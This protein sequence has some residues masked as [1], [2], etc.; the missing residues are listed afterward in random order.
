VST[1]AHGQGYSKDLSSNHGQVRSMTDSEVVEAALNASQCGDVL[2]IPSRQL[3]TTVLPHPVCLVCIGNKEF[4][5]EYRMK[6]FPQKDLLNKHVGTHFRG[7]K[8]QSRFQCRHPTCLAML[9]GIKHFKRHAFDV[10]GI[11]H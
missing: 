4:S 3:Y 10:H 11:S 9:E 5:D 6:C 1:K 8:F 2:E 7:P